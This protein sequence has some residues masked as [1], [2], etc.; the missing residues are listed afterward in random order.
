[1]RLQLLYRRRWLLLYLPILA[2]LVLGCAWAALVWTSTSSTICTTIGGAVRKAASV[3][4]RALAVISRCNPR[5]SSRSIAPS[6]TFRLA[7][8]RAISS[9][10]PSSEYWISAANS[11][12][13]RN[14]MA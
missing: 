4:P 3:A 6:A 11:E 1:M 2:G 14:C 8:R 9:I 12:A 7:K 5:G 13:I 10:R